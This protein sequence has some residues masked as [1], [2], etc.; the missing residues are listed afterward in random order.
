MYKYIIAYTY[1]HTYMY[2]YRYLLQCVVNNKQSMLHIIRPASQLA[3]KQASNHL[4]KH[5]PHTYIHTFVRTANDEL[6]YTLRTLLVSCAAA[7]IIYIYFY[8]HTY[9]HAHI[10]TYVGMYDIHTSAANKEIKVKH[11]KK[12]RK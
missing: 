6:I 10:C 4:N 9:M 12:I 11:R 8:I 1:V 7:Y 5:Q 2:I 3:S